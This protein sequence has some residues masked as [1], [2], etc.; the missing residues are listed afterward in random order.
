MSSPNIEKRD[1]TIGSVDAGQLKAMLHDAGEIALLDVREAGQ[2]GASHLL[3]AT[4]VPYSRLE[5]DVV[6]LEPRRSVRLV[7]CDDGEL[8]VAHLAAE[9]LSALGYTNIAVLDGG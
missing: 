6:A 5:L 9:R 8:G 7:V 1:A 4:P 3:F 2:F